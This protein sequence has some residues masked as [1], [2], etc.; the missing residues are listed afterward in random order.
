LNPRECAT[1]TRVEAG[2]LAEKAGFR[3]GDEILKFGGQTPLSIADVQWV[4][5]HTPS[6]GGTVAAT[7]SREGKATELKLTLPADWK[8]L[9]DIAWRAS[10]WELR[11]M[12]L[13]GLF[14]KKMP[15]EMRKE[16]KL[17]DEKMVLRAQHVGQ[18]A[19]HNAAKEAGIK[20]GDI[21]VSFDGKNDFLRETDLLEYALNDVKPGSSV[22]VVVLRDG[23]NVELTLK[24]PK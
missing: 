15:A 23:K 21:L 18:Y 6:E 12:G 24:V 16:L 14:L 19:P 3:P 10:T 4:L 5:H 7:V 11:R 20:V 22:P 13:G 1:V 2:S 17:P 8:Q 9:D